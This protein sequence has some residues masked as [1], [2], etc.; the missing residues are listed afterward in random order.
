MNAEYYARYCTA[1]QF[2][3]MQANFNG[4]VEYYYG[5]IW[6]SSNTSDKH[7]DILINIANEIRS[8]SKSI[9]CKVKTEG[10][11]VIFDKEE[12]YKFKPDVFIVC[13]NDIDNMKGQSYTTPPKIIF[14]IVSPGHQDAIRDKQLKYN[15]YETYGV[16]EYNIVEENGFIIQHSLKDGYYQIVNTFKDNDFY[17]SVIFPSIKIN[18]KNIF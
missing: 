14:E 18:L 7:N 6:F 12:K 11:E 4:K 17:E 8:Y 3:N 10:A 2:D 16:L 15:V 9:N 1:E 5:D 13:Q